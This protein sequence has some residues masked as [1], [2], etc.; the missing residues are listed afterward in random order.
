MSVHKI[1][2]T[3][4]RMVINPQ[5][6]KKERKLVHTKLLGASTSLAEAIR[7]ANKQNCDTIIS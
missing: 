3:K 7:F 1:S 6:Q 5:S 4:E 2:A